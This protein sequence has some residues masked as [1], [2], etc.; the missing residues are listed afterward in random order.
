MRLA[1]YLRVSTDKQAEEGNG[2]DVQERM[3]RAWARDHRHELV[4]VH[5]DAGLSGT[6]P[7]DERPGL[8]A[9]LSEVRAGEVD[10]VVVRDLD[11]LAREVTVQEAVLADLW[12][13]D[14][15]LVFAV[16][17]GLVARDDPD[18]PMRTAMRQMMGVFAG[19]ERR[20][21]VKRMRDGRKAKAARGGHAVGR[22]AFGWRAEGSELVPV[23]EEQVVLRRILRLHKAGE[24]TRAIAARLNAD[25]EMGTTKA[26]AAWS[27][28]VVSRILARQQPRRRTPRAA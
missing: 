21:L 6:L 14:D 19:L 9:V 5:T 7:A 26:G 2:L 10:G 27:S 16:T 25:P 8:A 1:A 11:R 23:P 3:I 22:P 17:S 24:S 28:Q 4:T 20:M 15:V 12:R 18:D 13:R